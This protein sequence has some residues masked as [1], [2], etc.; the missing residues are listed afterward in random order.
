MPT[1][2]TS[3]TQATPSL[4]LDYV[5]L[6]AQ[7]KTAPPVHLPPPVQ[8]ASVAIDVSRPP[9]VD[10]DAGED[11]TTVARLVSDAATLFPTVAF[12]NW[13]L[14]PTTQPALLANSVTTSSMDSA[15]LALPSAT[16]ASVRDHPL[17][18]DAEEVF[19]WLTG[20]V[21]PELVATSKTAEDA[22]VETTTA[23]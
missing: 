15:R 18:P 11:D 8:L 5:A 21:T 14:P 3:V 7:W 13:T 17:A 10:D 20:S 23:A 12:V 16:V 4:L 22:S 19:L 9:N 1:D 2:A 6:I